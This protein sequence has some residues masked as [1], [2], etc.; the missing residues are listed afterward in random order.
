MA[1]SLEGVLPIDKPAGITSF[2]LVALLR[3]LTDVAKIGHAGTLDP[4][5]TGVMLL[6]VGRSYTRLSDRF[7]ASDK[8]YLATLHLGIETDSHD[9][10]GKQ[11]STSDLIPSL[12]AIEETLALF[13]GWQEQIP[14]MYSAKKLQGKKLYELARQGIAVERPPSSV[15]ME[16]EL[17][18]YH[19]PFLEVRLR[20]SKGTYVRGLA[21]DLGRRLGCGAHLQKL[22]RT[23]SG[24]ISLE[25]CL[26][27]GSL[28]RGEA[29]LDSLASHW[30]TIDALSL[31]EDADLPLSTTLSAY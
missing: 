17:I 12:A 26:D 7:M 15:F 18:A 3:R 6:L 5:A 13:A 21:R 1:T 10:E 22:C 16:P 14:P 27:G 23:R 2:K 24:S 28:V 8:E 29:S 25:S 9:I 31:G 11:V 30:M 19:Y 20:C 4:F